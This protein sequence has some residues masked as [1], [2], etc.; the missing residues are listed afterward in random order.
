MGCCCRWYA[1]RA[2]EIEGEDALTAQS[3]L[4]VK[5]EGRKPLLYLQSRK[6]EENSVIMLYGMLQSYM[7]DEHFDKDLKPLQV[8]WP[9]VLSASGAAVSTFILG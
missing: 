4:V 5:L 7:S 9:A 6:N 3:R 8:W 1:K 2:S